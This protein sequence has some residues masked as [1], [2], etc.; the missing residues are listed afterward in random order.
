MGIDTSNVHLFTVLQHSLT[1]CLAERQQCVYICRDMEKEQTVCAVHRGISIDVGGREKSRDRSKSFA[2]RVSR[3][4]MAMK[5]NMRAFRSTY[6]DIGLGH[7]GRQSADK[8]LAGSSLGDRGR[9][10]RLRSRLGRLLH[11]SNGGCL[12]RCAAGTTTAT[13]SVASG[14]ATAADE[15]VK[16][17]IKVGRHGCDGIAKLAICKFSKSY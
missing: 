2:P 14:L 9:V 5:A 11:T 6:L 17:F 4:E 3:K 15:I 13:S 10:S 7:I 12:G 8:N 16:R 1:S